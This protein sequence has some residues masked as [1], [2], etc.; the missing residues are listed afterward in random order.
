MSDDG[1][2]GHCLYPKV[3][4]KEVEFKVLTSKAKGMANVHAN[5]WHNC[6]GLCNLT[7]QLYISYFKQGE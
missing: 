5:T 4:K 3:L 2:Q 1:E 6:M 7:S